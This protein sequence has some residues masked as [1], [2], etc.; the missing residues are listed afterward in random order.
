MSVINNV[1]KNLETRETNFTPIEIASLGRD[2]KEQRRNDTRPVLITVLT[3]FLVLGGGWIYLLNKPV[4]STMVAEMQKPV[5]ADTNEPVVVVANLVVEPA[6]LPVVDKTNQIIGLQIRESGDRMRLEF[7]LRGKA[8]TY[9]KERGEN[10]FAYHLRDIDSQI[11]APQLTDNR[12]IEQLAIESTTRGVDIHF[13]TVS[14]ILVETRQITTDGEFIWSIELT[15]SAEEV[16]AEAVASQPVVAQVVVEPEAPVE[17]AAVEESS[18]EQVA[19]VKLEIKSINA[20]AGSANDL[21]YAIELIKSRRHAEAE[22]QLIE[23]LNGNEDYKVRQHLLA[24]YQLQ[25]KADRH[26]QLARESM[27]K[28][29]GDVTLTYEYAHSLYKQG[30]YREVIG[31]FDS[32]GQVVDVNQQSILAASYQRLDQHKNAERYYNLALK[33]NA[34]NSRNWIGLAISQEHNSKLEAAL[35]SYQTASNLG[36]LNSRLQSFAAKRSDTLKKVLN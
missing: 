21:A 2:E 19:P 34:N 1:L 17:A 4:E 32:Q 35:D 20:D 28:Y 10:S 24:L 15:H 11:V 36:D 26:S 16:I 31:L 23:L 14:N 5:V 33:Q 22:K 7:A 3:V 25:G 27:Q 29:S 13:R 30:S 6:Q 8:V 12:W 18:K 9:L